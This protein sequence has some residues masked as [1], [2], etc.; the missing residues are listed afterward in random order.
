MIIIWVAACGVFVPVPERLTTCVLPETPLLLSVMLSVPVSGP[1]EAG[2][3]VTLMAQLLPAARLE[4]QVLVSAKLPL[5]VIELMVSAAVPV[6]ERVTVCAALVVPCSWLP[7]LRLTGETP[8]MGA[9]P[10]P[11]RLTV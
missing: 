10:V 1:V 3:K 11:V 6:F 7:K 8:A 9:T 4:P 5:A 2:V